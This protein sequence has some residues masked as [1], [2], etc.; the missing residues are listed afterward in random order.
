MTIPR[1]FMSVV[2]KMRAREENQRFE[3]CLGTTYACVSITAFVECE[4]EGSTGPSR[5]E[6][7][8]TVY[9]AHAS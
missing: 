6:H 7:R 2:C 1:F 3:I 9:R 5:G 4:R 8:L